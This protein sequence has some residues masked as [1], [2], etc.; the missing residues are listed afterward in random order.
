M[1]VNEALDR[2]RYAKA[3]AQGARGYGAAASK[4]VRHLE[5][6]AALQEELKKSHEEGN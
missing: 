1:L 2:P 5:G 4:L 3:L 6:L